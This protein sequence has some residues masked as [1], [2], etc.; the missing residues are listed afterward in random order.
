MLAL[1]EVTN[2]INLLL[3]PFAQIYFIYIDCKAQKFFKKLE[4]WKALYNRAV[5]FTGKQTL[6]RFKHNITIFN[7]KT[8]IISYRIST[9]Q[10]LSERNPGREES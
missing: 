5:T 7:V 9:K 8:E 1:K 6:T 10:S 4:K 3:R 2:R